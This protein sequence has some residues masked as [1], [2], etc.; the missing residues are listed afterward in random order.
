[1]ESMTLR[2]APDEGFIDPRRPAWRVQELLSIQPRWRNG[3]PAVIATI[4]G[5]DLSL[6]TAVRIAPCRNSPVPTLVLGT[7]SDGPRTVHQIPRPLSITLLAGFPLPDTRCRAVQ[8]ESPGWVHSRAARLGHHRTG[9]H[10]FCMVWFVPSSRWS[11]SSVI[12]GFLK[13]V[14]S[15]LAPRTRTS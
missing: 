2:N 3:L 5:V 13:Q 7:S 11:R 8:R 9:V 14:S 10:S 6:S 1:M 15:V 4:A 12:H